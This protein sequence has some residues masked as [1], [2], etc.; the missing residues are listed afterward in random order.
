[1]ELELTDPYYKE[2]SQAL[3]ALHGVI[4]PEL[5]INIVDLGLVYDL[6]FSD[7]NEITITM[8]LTTPHC[9]LEEAISNGVDNAMKPI[10]PDHKLNLNIVWEPEWN[11]DMMSEE[12]RDQLGL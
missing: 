8:T 2:K 12:A 4:D 5:Y 6:D 11:M 9:P 1:M 3:T 7:K 10:F